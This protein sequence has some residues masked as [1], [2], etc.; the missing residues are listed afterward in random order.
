MTRILVDTG[1]QLLVSAQVQRNQ[2][3]D[4]FT[5]ASREEIKDLQD[6]LVNENAEIFERPGDCGL[7]VCDCEQLPAW[8]TA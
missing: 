2:A 6:S 5:P 1:S 4:S 7:S 8:V 3:A